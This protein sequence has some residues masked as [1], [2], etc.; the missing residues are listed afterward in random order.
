MLTRGQ[1]R[2]YDFIKDFVEQNEFAPTAS[3]IA[4]GIGITSRGVVH[5]YLK[6]LED[7][8]HIELIP[9]RH[10]NIKLLDRA[11]QFIAKGCVPL[12]GAI[13]AGEPIE[14]IADADPIDISE[15]FLGEGHY[16]LRVKGDSMIDEGIFDGDI[17]V[18]KQAKTARD[19]EIVVALI[20]QQQATLKRFQH[21]DGKIILHPANTQLSPMSFESSRVMIQGTYIGLL[22]IQP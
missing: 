10:R 11:E 6:A 22:R 12:I 5:R 13:A 20:D 17:V 21:K 1:R 9:K 2:T 19:G 8:G 14:A 4:L 18:C 16:A 3:E 7:A 15:L